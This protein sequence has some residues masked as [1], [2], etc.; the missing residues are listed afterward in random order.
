[1]K[2]LS[3]TVAVPDGA[4]EIVAD[5]HLNGTEHDC[6]AEVFDTTFNVLIL[7]YPVRALTATT[8][9]MS[10]AFQSIIAFDAS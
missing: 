1:M 4:P 8:V 9:I 2:N 6:L 7:V 10:P 5:L 3:R